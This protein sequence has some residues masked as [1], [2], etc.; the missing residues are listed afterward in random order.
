MPTGK[1]ITIEGI[2]GAGK[3]TA[4]AFIRD[5]FIK[6]DIEVIVTRE[7]GGTAVG[8]KIRHVLLDFV[9]EPLTAE[10][11][12]LLMFASRSQHIQHVIKPALNTGRWV[13]SDRYIDASYAYQGGGRKL[14]EKIIKILDQFV[15]DQ[16]YP[17]LT[18]LLDLPVLQGIKRTELRGSQKDRIEQE[19]VTFFTRVRRAYLKRAQTDPNRIKVIDS[20]HALG[21]VQDQ[22][23]HHLIKFMSEKK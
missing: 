5:F 1:F 8:E 20:S 17:D 16:L 15:V 21:L 14:D 22:I 11:E 7:P 9:N 19:K 6:Q 3:S 4:L 18:L 12:L 13:I 2:E 10:S 23:N